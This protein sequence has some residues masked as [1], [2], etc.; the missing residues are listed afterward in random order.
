MQIHKVWERCTTV[1]NHIVWKR[2]FIL[3]FYFKFLIFPYSGFFVL[4]DFL[5][6]WHLMIGHSYNQTNRSVPEQMDPNK[7]FSRK[8]L[9]FEKVR[10]GKIFQLYFLEKKKTLASQWSMNL[11]SSPRTPSS[12]W[13]RRCIFRRSDAV[14]IGDLT[15]ERFPPLK[16]SESPLS[17][18]SG[19]SPSLS[20]SLSLYIYIYIYVCMQ[21]LFFRFIV[22]FKVLAF[23]LN[24]LSFYVCVCVCGNYIGNFQ[25]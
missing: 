25:I 5:H 10:V 18:D 6:T 11:S 9:V 22:S 13:R 7:L 15:G 2:Y 21:C 8:R 14:G 16:R 17:V 1:Q 12:P 20:L 3:F 23:G 19:I 4:F 24:S